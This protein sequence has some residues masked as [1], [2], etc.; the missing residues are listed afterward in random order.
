MSAVFVDTWAWVTWLDRNEPQH[1]AVDRIIRVGSDD[2]GELVT[3]NAVMYECMSLLRRRAGHRI[4]YGFL[5][6]LLLPIEPPNGLTIVQVDRALEASAAAI[7]RRYDDKDFS[8]VDCLSFAVM[9]Q[10][11]I[12]TAL[13]GDKHFAQM[14]FEVLP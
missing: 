9:Q 4:A 12:A 3:T 6:R 13:T 10:R 14:G 11:G 5:E 2:G 8:F 1:A 7:F